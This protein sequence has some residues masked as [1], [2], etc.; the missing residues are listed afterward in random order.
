VAPTKV[1]FVAALGRSGTTIV[2]N[3]LNAYP[4]VFSAGELLYL[5]ERGLI[6]QRNCGCGRPVPTCSLW[7]EI[8]DVAYGGR[9][10]APRS[11]YVLQREAMRVRRTHRLWRR[12]LPAPAAD[13][14]EILAPLYWA[15]AQVTGAELIVDA[16][17]VPAAAALLTHVPGI[18]PWLLHVVR[19]PRAVAHSWARPTGKL[20]GSPE[21]MTQQSARVSAARWLVWNA[22]I[23]ATAATYAGRRLRMRYEDFAAAPQAEMDRLL[24]FV[25]VSSTVSPFVDAH[26]VT[27]S[28]NHTVSGNPARF[29]V[30][31]VPIRPDDAWRTRLPR[32]S[33]RTVTALT[34]PL[35]RRY[36]YPVLPEA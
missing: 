8:L 9:P 27:L 22:Y 16:S 24:A 23:E 2:D 7:R 5:W 21:L 3:V 19:D 31:T 4:G 1:L 17:K 32:Q 20:D 13:Y 33:R 12:P 14:A 35:L 34:L 15:I 18:E 28:P 6:Y 29:T 30:G 26:T 10:P 25:G 36:R 11:V